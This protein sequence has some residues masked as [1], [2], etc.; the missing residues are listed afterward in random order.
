[1]LLCSQ[2]R[3]C[4]VCAM[5][6]LPPRPGS[7]T[8]A[9]PP[10]I[11]VEFSHIAMPALNSRGVRAIGQCL[12]FLERA[13]DDSHHDCV[14]TDPACSLRERVHRGDRLGACL[15]AFVRRLRD[16][17]IR[18]AQVPARTSSTSTTSIPTRRRA[19]RSYL[20][21]SRPPHAASTSSIRS[22]SRATAPAGLA[23][24]CSRR[25]RCR[26]A[27]SRRRCTACSPRRCWSRP[28]SRR[29][30]SAST[31]RRAS[32]TATRSPPTTSS[33]S[34]DTLTSK[35]AAP[36]LPDRATRAI[37]RAVVVDR[38]HDPLRPA[39]TREHA[40]VQ[41]RRDA[42]GV[43]A[44]V[45]HRRRRQ[46]EAVRPDRHR[47]SDHQR[48]V[49]DRATDSGRRIEF[50]RNPRLLGA[51]P[52]ACGAASSTSTAS[53]TATTRTAPSRREAFKAGEFDFYKRVRRAQLGAPAQAAR[54]GTTGGS[55]R[56]RSR[57]ASARACSRTILNLR[58]PMFQDVACAR[59]S[60]SPTTS[61]DQ[62]LQ[63]VQARRQLVQQ[64][65][66]RGARAAVRRRAEAARAVPQASCRPRCSA[67]P[68]VR[69]AHRR[70]RRT[71]CART[72]SRRAT[73]SRTPA[74]S[75]TATACCATPRASRSSSSTST[76]RATA[77]DDRRADWRAI[78][79]SS[80]ST[81]QA[82]ATSTSRC[83]QQA[84]RGVRLRHG[85]RSSHARLHAAAARD[86]VDALRQQG[87][88]RAGLEQPFA[89]SRARP[90]TRSST[91]WP[92]RRRASNCATP[93]ARSTG[94]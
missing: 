76:T 37:E 72:C 80:A 16:R 43:L 1:M 36:T 34:F 59:R 4:A 44:Q 50:K 54:S 33:I 40:A 62:P 47:V 31:R 17:A 48:P 70:R 51:R 24:S 18:R 55:S 91:R 64:L 21:Q 61:S 83:I 19:A 14:A 63:P 10:L 28:T 35:Q 74:G 68:Y 30:R 26:R 9:E 94:S 46:A 86:H 27:T 90:S 53:S 38:A 87:G 56:T 93:R 67:R 75:S 57:P 84:P 88:R 23:S 45:G 58:R 39:A 6:R 3:A 66:F 20:A 7:N 13:Y 82:A 73:C 49:H 92:T 81:L 52:A 89:A 22:R 41:R 11:W 8:R 25:W 15:H 79:R 2:C 5:S 69:A 29:S 85:R 42:P 60:I 71:R 12:F 77:R 32:T 65:R 78:C